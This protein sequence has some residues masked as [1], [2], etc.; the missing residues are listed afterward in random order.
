V[1][2]GC[3]WFRRQGALVQELLPPPAHDLRLVV[4][5]GTLVGGACRAP[6]EGEWRTNISL[7]GRLLP[8]DPEP[9]AERLALAAVFAVGGDLVG[10]DLLPLPG[11][12]YS[13]IELN[14]AAEFDS[15]YS[16]R[17][18]N[19]YAAIAHALGFRAT[20][21][22]DGAHDPA[23]QPASCRREA[24]GELAEPTFGEPLLRVHSL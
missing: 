15:G 2:E 14:I 13:I 23:M 4:A 8:A 24:Q 10:V 22:R 17:G 1:L 5:G 20:Q 7:G 12:G 11:G 18:G 21:D 6:A 19:V 9:E 16:L 3:R